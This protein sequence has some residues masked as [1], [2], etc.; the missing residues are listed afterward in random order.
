MADF[1]FPDLGLNGPA[2]KL[3]LHQYI[4]AVGVEEAE[5][6]NAWKNIMRVATKL[7]PKE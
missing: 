4:V 6:R 3:D 1:D 2:G 7:A 5:F